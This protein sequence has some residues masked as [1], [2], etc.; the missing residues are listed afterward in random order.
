MKAW[1]VY[2]SHWGNTA[3]IARAIA[4]GIGAGTKAV[5]TAEAKAAEVPELD[6]L[7]VGAPVLGFRLSTQSM[8]DQMRRQPNKGNPPNLSHPPAREW[9]ESVPAGGAAVAAF[10]TR[11][12]GPFGTAAPAILKLLGQAGYRQVAE[13][14]GFL[15]KGRQGPMRDGEIERA[16]E[17]GK[18]LAAAAH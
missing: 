7:V 18:E 5:S 12:R 13:P 3:E 2:E 4:E 14:E 11:A 9:L 16:R 15:V 17:W 1:V 6:L 8:Y 10:D